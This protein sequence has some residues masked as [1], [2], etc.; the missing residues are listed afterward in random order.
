MDSMVVLGMVVLGLGALQRRA[1]TQK[2]GQN[3]YKVRAGGTTSREKNM[4]RNSMRKTSTE[5]G[6]P[7][8]QQ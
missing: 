6:E 8:P 2:G 7:V 4:E 5:K 1:W 3:A